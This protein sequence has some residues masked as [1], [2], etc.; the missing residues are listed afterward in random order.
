MLAQ[1]VIRTRSSVFAKSVLLVKKTD[2]SWWFCVD[3][4]ALNAKTV[5]DKFPIPVVEE[6]LDELWVP[7]SS[8]SSTCTLD[9]TSCL[10]TVTT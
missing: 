8:P 3:Y 5:S 2:D 1:G 10:C 9:T 7:P 6:L 4:R